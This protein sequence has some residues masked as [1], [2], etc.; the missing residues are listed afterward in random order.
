MNRLAPS[1]FDE[2]GNPVPGT[3][4]LTETANTVASNFGPYGSAAAAIPLLIWNFVE[5]VRAKRDQRGLI[6]TVKAIDEAAKNPTIKEAAEKIKVYL[7][8][9]HKIAGVNKTIDGLLTKV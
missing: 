6:A 2:A 7:G 8:S 1:S 3:H 9:A 5:L 4:E